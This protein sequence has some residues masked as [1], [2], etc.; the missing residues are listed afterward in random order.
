MRKVVVFFLLFA[1]LLSGCS[2]LGDSLSQAFDELT[3]T[4]PDHQPTLPIAETIPEA[5]PT[6]PAVPTEPITPETAPTPPVVQKTY[7][8]TIISLNALLLGMQ[9][10]SYFNQRGSVSQWSDEA[11]CSAIHAKLMWYEYD[12]D[13]AKFMEPLDL[14]LQYGTDGNWDTSYDLAAIDELTRSCFGR[15]YPR[16]NN[17]DYH[18]ISGNR[19]CIMMAAGESESMSIQSVI[20]QG[21][22]LTAIGTAVHHNNIN[23]VFDGYFTAKFVENPDSLYGYTLVSYDETAGNQNFSFLTAEASSILKEPSFTHYASNVLDGS[24]STAWV[25]GVNGVGEGEWIQLS[26]SA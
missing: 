22:T 1:L 18:Y 12:P 25:E 20:T 8:E 5:L 2:G 10:N 17:T 24:P 15:E 3:P 14:D 19:L 6:T 4:L 11:I 16:S 7:E 9:H 26:S 23:T 21:N 13:N